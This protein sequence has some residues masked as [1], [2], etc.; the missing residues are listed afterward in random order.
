[1]NNSSFV[2]GS[3]LGGTTNIDI[4]FVGNRF[5]MTLATVALLRPVL[6]AIIL[7]DSPEELRTRILSF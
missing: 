6:E 7:V 1:M 3:K 2:M 5:L 4:F